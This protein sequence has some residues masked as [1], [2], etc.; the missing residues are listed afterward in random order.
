MNITISNGTLTA[1]I[2]PKG[3]ELVSL[4]HKDREF[5]WEGNPEYWGKHSPVLFPI[6]GTLKNNS[7]VYEGKSY[8][9][10][11]HGFARDNEFTVKEKSESKVVFSLVYNTDT[12]T[13]YPFKFELEL[14]YTLSGTSLNIEYI[15]KNN[16]EKTM[17]FSIGAHPAFA[18]PKNFESY[19]LKFEQDEELISTQLENDLLSRKTVSIDVKGGLLPLSYALFDNDALIFKELQSK[20]VTILEKDSPIVKV[21]F[22]HFP[23]LGI[24]TK[25]GAP[26]ICIEPWQGYSDSADSNGILAEKEGMLNLKPGHTYT[27][28]FTI[29]VFE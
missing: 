8:A 5:I 28:G 18:L 1:Q 4:K 27:T 24:W 3:A 2:N 16:D 14:H 19:S 26:F 15:I 23:H 25:K 11:R 13:V 22:P 21:S 10:T 9:L 12:L 17:P 7:Y 6:V 20:S 29:A